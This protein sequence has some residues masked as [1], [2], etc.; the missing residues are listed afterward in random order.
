MLSGMEIEKS[1]KKEIEKLVGL[2]GGDNWTS[3]TR[4]E[5]LYD[6]VE[7]IYSFGKRLTYQPK[8]NENYVNLQSSRNLG[9]EENE[10]FNNFIKKAKESFFLREEDLKRI[11]EVEE[12]VKEINGFVEL[13][14]R[15]PVNLDYYKK[16]HNAKVKGYDVVP[17]SV[18]TGRSFGYDVDLYDLSLC[19]GDLEIGE[20]D[21]VVCYHVL[22]HVTDPSVPIKKIYE[23]MK[24]GSFFHTEVPIEPGIP[25]LRY[26][27]LFPFQKDDLGTMLKEAGF[28]IK[29]K[30]TITETNSE[31]YLVIK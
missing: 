27:H 19:E 7:R 31:R 13:G 10:E 21:V 25:R 26:A 1:I 16:T 24:K 14:F 23:E 18:M 12:N 30:N 20:A 9:I 28:T 8:K 17:I 11:R 4:N 2:K 15:L 3:S 22:E 5:D 6:L 29:F